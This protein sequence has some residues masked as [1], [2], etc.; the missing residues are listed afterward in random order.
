MSERDLLSA[1]TI[2]AAPPDVPALLGDRFEVGSLIAYGGMGSVYR[3]HDRLLDRAV[4][5]KVLSARHRADRQLAARFRREAAALAGLEHPHIVPIYAVGETEGVPWLAMKLLAG[6]PL[7]Q[8]IRARQA[9]S[10][11]AAVHL[12][13]QLCEA[14]GHLHAAGYIHRD[15]KPGNVMASPDGQVSLLDLGIA[16]AADS[17]L[18]RTGAA[19]G[20]PMFMSPEQG[21]EAREVDARSDLYSLG[22]TLY[23]ALTGRAP[24]QAS[25]GYELI[26]LHVTAMPEA[27]SRA[28]PGLPAAL[29]AFIARAMAKAPADRFQSASE[30]GAALRALAA[31]DW[32]APL[33]GPPTS[34]RRWPLGLAAGLLLGTA[35]L[36][37][38]PGDPPPEAPVG[39]ASDTRPAP[40]SLAP[41]APLPAVAPRTEPPVPSIVPSSAAPP[42]PR[43][44]AAAASAVPA[45]PAASSPEP[46]RPAIVRIVTRDAHGA[47]WAQIF[48]DDT[49]LGTS[50]IN[51]ARLSPGRHAV[52]AR[53]E[54]YRPATTTV[55]LAA[56]EER[57]VVLQLE[58]LGASP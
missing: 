36:L 28:R 11:P 38:M 20:S 43:P 9:L 27:P 23:A 16:R 12:G 18:T 3:G 21:R 34:R 31:P 35:A 29:D 24:F 37:A 45:S 2:D 26:H 4:A 47:S 48:V 41:S 13:L 10:L 54:G 56:G 44:S 42:R 57:R 7:D 55:D 49:P 52:T 25:S 33:E 1:E 5:L 51:G 32:D 8:L 15:V 40:P 50:P 58:S 19:V 30:M 22:A 39:A 53:R 46:A 14:L 17:E 6:Q